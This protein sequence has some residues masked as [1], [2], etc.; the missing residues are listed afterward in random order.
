MV[1]I[2]ARKKTHRR[3]HLGFINLDIV[4]PQIHQLRLQTR[5][6]IHGFIFDL[7]CNLQLH[8][9]THDAMRYSN[10]LVLTS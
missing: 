1:L 8:A 9:T 2:D 6:Y 4:A 10:A 3:E 7:F 5:I